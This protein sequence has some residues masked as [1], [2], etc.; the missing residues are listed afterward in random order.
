L[1]K[2]YRKSETEHGHFNSRFLDAVPG[3]VG[4]L[5]EMPI[6]IAIFEEQASTFAYFLFALPVT[7]SGVAF[8]PKM[9]VRQLSNV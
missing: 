1:V 7:V 2:I 6:H 9:V 8:V 3:D 4:V 5:R